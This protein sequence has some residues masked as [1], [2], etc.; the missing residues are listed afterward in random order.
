MLQMVPGPSKTVIW[1]L[2][3]WMQYSTLLVQ[4]ARCVMEVGG[5]V[6]DDDSPKTIL[7]FKL[8]EWSDIDHR[9]RDGT[10]FKITNIYY[11]LYVKIL[12]DDINENPVTFEVRGHDDLNELD[13]EGKLM[14]CFN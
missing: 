12:N 4:R 9:Y 7:R 3:N 11:G 8:K 2:K 14:F 6:G 1:K 13:T 10:S 5:G